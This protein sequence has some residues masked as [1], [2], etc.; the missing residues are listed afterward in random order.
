MLLLIQII[1]S[2]TSKVEKKKLNLRAIQAKECHVTEIKRRLEETVHS[3]KTK[4][5][6]IIK[7][8]NVCSFVSFAYHE[9]Q[10]TYL[11]LKKK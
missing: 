3:A 6:S 1:K 8:P 10:Y 11:V 7:I 2:M 5:H 4:R 9:K